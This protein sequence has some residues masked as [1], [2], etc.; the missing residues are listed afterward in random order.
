MRENLCLQRCDSFLVCNKKR[1]HIAFAGF[2]RVISWGI[3]L[4]CFHTSVCFLVSL[5]SIAC[6]AHVCF[7]PMWLGRFCVCCRHCLAS[8]SHFRTCASEFMGPPGLGSDSIRLSGFWRS[9]WGCARRAGVVRRSSLSCPSVV[10]VAVW[11][12]ALRR[13]PISSQ[14]T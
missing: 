9:C 14:A 1:P 13:A 2:P 8:V 3:L 12:L 4:R 7:N 11:G 6:L 5:A 10:V